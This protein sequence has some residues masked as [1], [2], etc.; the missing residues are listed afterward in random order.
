MRWTVLAWGCHCFLSEEYIGHNPGARVE[1]GASSLAWEWGGHLCLPGSGEANF[2]FLGWFLGPLI[3]LPGFPRMICQV[4][5][6]WTFTRVGGVSPTLLRVE[7]PACFF[8]LK[9]KSWRPYH[10][11]H[12]FSDLPFYSLYRIQVRRCLL[13]YLYFHSVAIYWAPTLCSRPS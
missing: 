12:T 8:F 9:K 1:K 5:S 10:I 6:N 3:I 4:L 2:I 13:I 7:A 11:Q